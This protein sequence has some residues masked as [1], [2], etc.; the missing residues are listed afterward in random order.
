MAQNSKWMADVAV[1]LMLMGMFA[2]VI[3]DDEAL[4]PTPTP[5]AA[6]QGTP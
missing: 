3:S 4:P 6:E 1:V 2:Y 5:P